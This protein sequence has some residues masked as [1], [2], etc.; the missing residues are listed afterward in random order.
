MWR[1]DGLWEG[2]SRG[3]AGD[4]QWE[5]RAAD[6]TK[7]YKATGG[8][9]V[10]RKD[11]RTERGRLRRQAIRPWHGGNPVSSRTKAEAAGRRAK[12][13]GP[14]EHKARQRESA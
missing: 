12:P 3:G 11:T 10:N 14:S 4:S 1:P 2:S 13:T 5:S 9:P 6:S 7:A 8:H